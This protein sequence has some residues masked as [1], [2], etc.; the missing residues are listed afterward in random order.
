MLGNPMLDVAI[1]LIFFYVLLSTIITVLQE[2]ISSFLKWRNENLR[3]AIA[4]L[5]GEVN[6]KDFFE[7]PLILPLFQGGVNGSGDP[8]EGGPSYIPKR[9]F[10]LTVFDLQRKNG[11]SST[12]PVADPAQP[13]AFALAQFFIDAASSGT[14]A[15]RIKQFDKTATGLIGNI[16]NAT[17]QKAATDAL[18]AAVSELKTATDIVDTAVKEIEFLFDSVMD[19]AS[20]WYK[21]KAQRVALMISLVLAVILNADTIYLA[22]RLWQDE[23][24]RTQSVAAAEAF[25]QSNAGQTQ[26][27]SLCKTTVQTADKELTA[28]QWQ[29]VKDCT[30]EKIKEA[31]NQLTTAGYPIGW[32]WK[33]D[34]NPYLMFAGWMLTALALSLGSGFWFDVLGKFMNVRMTGK[35]EETA[36]SSSR[37]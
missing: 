34:Q 24:L 31:M 3:M 29:A 6:K 26:L 15:E 5:I 11:R 8:I 36:S 22:Q 13:P 27:N 19:R 2:F 28:E 10:A 1:G 17:V 14:L 23:A 7:H 33:P 25:Y 18:T 20:G 12:G 4:E 21:V 37:K 35:R 9:N 30:Q 16:K 32:P